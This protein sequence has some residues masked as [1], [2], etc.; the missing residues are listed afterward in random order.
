MSKAKPG[1]LHT[2]FFVD[3]RIEMQKLGKF[4]VILVILE[5]VPVCV[6]VCVCMYVCMGIYIYILVIL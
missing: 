4:P 3:S 5:Y 2:I 6:C 1:K